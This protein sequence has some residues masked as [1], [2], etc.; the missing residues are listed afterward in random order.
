[1]HSQSTP[2]STKCQLE[3]YCARSGFCREICR[4][5]TVVV[6]P[7]I[8]F[9]TRT[10]SSLSSLGSF[11]EHQSIGTHNSAI[12]AAYGFGV[13][14]A[15]Y[16]T[17]LASSYLQFNEVRTLS[18]YFSITDQ[19]NLGVRHIELDIHYFHR[20]LR[21]SHCGF[22]VGVVNYLFHWM[23]RWLRWMNFAYD[24]ETIGCLPSF[25]GIP[26]EDQLL[27]IPVLE[28]I[29]NWLK[30]ECNRDEF[31][32]LYLDISD[33]LAR[34]KQVR[35]LRTIIL[36]TFDQLLIRPSSSSSSSPSNSTIRLYDLIRMEKRVMI[37]SRRRFTEMDDIFFYTNT[38]ATCQYP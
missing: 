30:K 8:G 5:G 10:Q 27:A 24:T 34:W 12:T 31:V 9:A 37:V 35:E 7:W 20:Q 6:S 16:S 33:N 3:V 4:P 15:F 29:A 21:I 22:S 26:A 1:M 28:E 13:E 23:E 17:I 2:S 36:S 19:L 18:Q 32:I 25:N 14:D 11:C 38:S